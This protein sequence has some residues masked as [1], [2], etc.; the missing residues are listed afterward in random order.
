MMDE[1]QREYF[2]LA[3]PEVHRPVLSF[4]YDQY[5]ILDISEFGI[6]IKV[7]ADDPTFEMG[8]EVMAIIMF[9]EGREFDI[10]GHVVRMQDGAVGL[11]LDTPLPDSLIRSEALNVLYNFPDQK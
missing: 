9:P 4:E 7:D 6:K 2:R 5:E 8:D 11:E 1:K 10:T 3:Y